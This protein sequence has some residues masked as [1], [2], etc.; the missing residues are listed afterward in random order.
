[1]SAVS[2]AAE[3]DTS[4]GKPIY[5]L[6]DRDEQ[7]RQAA[8]LKAMTQVIAIDPTSPEAA[9]EG[10]SNSSDN[11]SFSGPTA[12]F[13]YTFILISVACYRAGRRRGHIPARPRQSAARSSFSIDTLRVSHLPVRLPPR[14][15]A[16]DRRSRPMAWCSS[17]PI[18]THRRC[19][20][21]PRS[22]RGGCRSRPASATALGSP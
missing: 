6:D 5:K 13:R 9:G 2:K 1:M 14:E 21:T 22:C 16:G 17:A 3:V 19:R 18:C 4:W 11:H 10:P 20:R 15:D 12:P 8:A 7:G